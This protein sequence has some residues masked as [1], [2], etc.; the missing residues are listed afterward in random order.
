MA[1]SQTKEKSETKKLISDKQHIKLLQ[2]EMNKQA[3]EGVE[4]KRQLLETQN[5]YSELLQIFNAKAESEEFWL[6][7]FDELAKQH[8]DVF[9]FLYRTVQ[10]MKD[11]FNKGALMTGEITLEDVEYH[12][13]LLLRFVAHRFL[14]EDEEN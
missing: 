14:K 4:C 12:M 13:N 8:D 7:K 9:D 11:A 2:N 3:Q 1:K 6:K 10:Q 5:A